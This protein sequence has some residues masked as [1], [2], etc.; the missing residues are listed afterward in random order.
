MYRT[1]LPLS[2]AFFDADGA[3]VSNADMPPCTASKSGDC[4]LY[5]ATGPY[6]DALEAVQGALPGLG[7]AAGSRIAV[8]GDCKRS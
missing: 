3:F 4:P 6:K 8:G 2:I 1:R 7:I 5:D